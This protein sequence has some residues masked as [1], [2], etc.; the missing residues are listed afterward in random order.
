MK[1]IL[2]MRIDN[3]NFNLSKISEFI[4]F[5]NSYSISLEDLSP[6]YEMN[7]IERFKKGKK[8]KI[9]K[10]NIGSFTKYCGGNVTEECIRKG[11]NSPDPKIRKKA[12]FAQ[13]ARGWK[14]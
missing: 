2:I 12:T 1:L 7:V 11:K 14:H 4:N 6:K 8:I 9:K 3:K 5:C 13:N 10:E